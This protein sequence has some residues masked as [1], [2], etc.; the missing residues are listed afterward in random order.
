[1]RLALIGATG[2]VGRQVL[3]EALG[4]GHAVTA[5][6]RHPDRLPEHELLTPREA[7][8]QDLRQVAEAVRG[9]DAV[10]SC[11][12]PGGH[13]GGADPTLYRDV[14][15]GTR[16]IIEGVKAAGLSRIVY[17]GGCGSLYVRPG[18]MLVD[19]LAVLGANM[20]QGRPEGTY[21]A[22]AAGKPSFDIPLAARMGFYLFEREDRLEWTFISPS[23][24]LGEFG[25]ATGDIRYGDDRLLLEPD[26]SPARLEV[27]D[28]AVAMVD[29]VEEP[30][31][32]RC[33]YTVASSFPA[34]A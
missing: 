21:P 16:S 24:F 8:V 5:I 33:H 20:K 28:L 1:M 3:D 4:R 2:F 11:F 26:G 9:H 29:E 30:R 23:R 14:V 18:V 7:D 13:D 19:D 27:A 17:V 25:D 15:E 32:I 6:V 31:H 10:L 12:H 22:P 34:S